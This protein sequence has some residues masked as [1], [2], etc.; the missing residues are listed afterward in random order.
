MYRFRR[1]VAL[2]VCAALATFFLSTITRS[3]PAKPGGSRVLQGCIP[4]RDYEQALDRHHLK[5]VY[6]HGREAVEFMAGYN[7]LEPVSDD[8]AEVLRFDTYF[9]MGH[10][11]VGIV[12]M[13][14]NCVQFHNAMSMDLFLHLYKDAKK[15]A[16][17]E[18]L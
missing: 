17:G 11:L 10:L 1:S 2:C 8:K 15:K 5:P 14:G 9:H 7:A 18:V 3:E 6:S 13:T 12:G 4:A 16:R